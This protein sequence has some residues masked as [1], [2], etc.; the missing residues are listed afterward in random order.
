M[1]LSKLSFVIQT[2]LVLWSCAPGVD[3]RALALAAINRAYQTQGPLCLDFQAFGQ[4]DKL[5][6]AR[7][8]EALDAFSGVHL[9]TVTPKKVERVSVLGGTIPADGYKVT[10]TPLGG[11]VYSERYQG[12]CLGTPKATEL[13]ALKLEPVEGH[14]NSRVGEAT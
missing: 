10:L 6:A 9:I 13:M 2:G 11:Q 3:D 5:D 12:F 1:Q 14:R 7:V 8:R 4:L